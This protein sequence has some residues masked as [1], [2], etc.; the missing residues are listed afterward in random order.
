MVEKH[1]TAGTTKLLEEFVDLIKIADVIVMSKHVISKH[2][3]SAPFFVAK[4]QFLFFYSKECPSYM[5]SCGE[6]YWP[7][8][9][10][11]HIFDS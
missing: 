8:Q 1:I 10:I 9:R 7:L 11:F 3:N 4:L 2:F 5:S 6:Q